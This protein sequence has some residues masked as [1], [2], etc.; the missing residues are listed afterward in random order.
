MRRPLILVIFL[1]PAAAMASDLVLEN[2]SAHIP[3]QC[4]TRTTDAAA[5]VHNPCSTCHVDGRAPNYI[6]DSD[7]QLRYDFPGPARVN[8][9]TN[10]FVDRSKA[11]AETPAAEIL[12]YVRQNNYHDAD[13]GIRLARTLAEV[14]A[15]WDAD[16]DGHWRGYVPDVAF[17][18]DEEGFDI[19][20]DGQD[21][22]W[23]AF[24]YLPLPGTFFPANGSAADV[25]IRLPAA[26][27]ERADGTPDRSIYKLNLATVE[28]LIQRR[29][30]AIPPTDEDALGVDLDRD[31]IL[32][33]ATR[34]DFAFDPRNGVTMHYLGRAGRLAAGEAPLAAGLYPLG[35]EFVHSLRYLDVAADGRIDMAPRMKELRYMRKTRWQTY[36]DLEEGAMA[37]IKEAEDF[38]DRMPLFFGDDESGVSNGA[39]WRL[40]AFIEDAEGELR[41]QTFEETVF[42]MGCHGGV[43]ATDDS[44]FAFARKPADDSWKHWTMRGGLHGLPDLVRADGEGDYAHYLR[45]NG[46]GDEYRGNMELIEAWLAD[47]GALDPGRAEALK[48][49]VG[50]LVYP[51]PERALA[52]DVAYREIVRDQSFIRGRDAT[53]TPQQN[54]WREVDPG[55]ETGVTT[56]EPAW[57]GR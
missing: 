15:D 21:N 14:P 44:T 27:R 1:A 28:A 3:P 29:D 8:P 57:F 30:I 24:I 35:T 48:A 20:R 46:A 18:F 53:V 16:G 6:D 45:V 52:L 23:R 13:G 12:A 19:D 22:G 47:A 4:Y 2:R 26:Y 31:G 11:V 55:H 36:A 10:L 5:S 54:V 37:E 9:W 17:R 7:L 38:P 51:S 42:C 40:Q 39:G 50:P 32:G 25:L 41:P 34:I 56:P 43:G 49:D 33:T